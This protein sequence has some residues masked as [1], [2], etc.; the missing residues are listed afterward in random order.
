[1][2]KAKDWPLSIETA[3]DADLPFFSYGHHPK[4]RFLL[5]V[6]EE[7]GEE[8]MEHCH[9]GVQH[10]YVHIK[11]PA[12]GDDE[13]GYYVTEYDKPGPFRRKATVLR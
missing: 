1:M 13:Y 5:R 12:F 11:A 9:D 10:S 7:Y 4:L 3:P 2:T 6:L 8:A